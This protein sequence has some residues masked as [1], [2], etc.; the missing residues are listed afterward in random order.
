MFQSVWDYEKYFGNIKVL[1]KANPQW[2]VEVSDDIFNIPSPNLPFTCYLASLFYG[3]IGSA[4]RMVF[5][6]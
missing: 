2:G 4:L 6:Q 1:I 5:G 3:M